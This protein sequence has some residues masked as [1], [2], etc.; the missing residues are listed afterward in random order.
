MPRSGGQAHQTVPWH[1]SNR[2]PGINH[3]PNRINLISSSQMAQRLKASILFPEAPNS[4]QKEHVFCHPLVADR[5]LLECG[6]R[7]PRQITIRSVD[8]ID[9]AGL[10]EAM[11]VPGTRVDFNELVI[12]GGWV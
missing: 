7:H 6:Q 8:Q 1:V 3:R 9:T 4:G 10:A 5:A 12:T 11:L 2:R